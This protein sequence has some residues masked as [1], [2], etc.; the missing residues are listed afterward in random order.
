MH[1]M[2]SPEDLMLQLLSQQRQR[3]NLGSIEENSEVGRELLQL[4]LTFNAN[5]DNSSDDGEDTTS[6]QDS[7]D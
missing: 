7:F 4:T 2:A 5:S 1:H 3:T 6:G